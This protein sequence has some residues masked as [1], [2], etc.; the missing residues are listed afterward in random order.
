MKANS[1]GSRQPA[2]NVW[3]LF[4]WFLFC[5]VGSSLCPAYA[6]D[7]AMQTNATPLIIAHRGASSQAPENTLPAFA[8]AWE[9]QA[10]GIELDVRLSQ[11]RKIVVCHDGNAKRT[12][13]RD[14]L[15]ANARWPELQALDAGLWKGEKWRG[16][17]LPELSQVLAALPAG[18]RIVIE[19]KDGAET[20]P[21]VQEAITSAQV[22]HAT[23]VIISFHLS[24]VAAA[25]KALPDCPVLLL[26]GWSKAPDGT[27]VFDWQRL[28][29]H[30]Q[31]ARL[32]GLNLDYHCVQKYPE[33]A[34]AIK[35]AGLRFYVWT[36]DDPAVA[37]QMTDL[38]AEG[39]TTN[40]P[41]KIREALTA[42]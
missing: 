14:L 6:A 41:D 20:V 28:I 26:A 13:G 39:L 9:L 32:T 1:P 22:P 24:V 15:I 40:W 21:A 3:A 8:R 34:R 31:E 42:P 29:Q 12:T 23:T 17:R 27:K 36:V 7:A 38:G 30:A 11:D 19:I 35:A 37:R 33:C 5:L 16:T 25:A 10:D 18:K 2:R 4:V